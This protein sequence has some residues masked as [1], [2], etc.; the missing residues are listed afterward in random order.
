M[1]DSRFF[2]LYS[3]ACQF[4]Q[5]SKIF[6]YEIPD[7]FQHT[8]P[9]HTHAHTHT[10][11][12]TWAI[13][14]R[15]SKTHIKEC[16]HNE[17]QKRIPSKFYHFPS[18]LPY[19][20]HLFLEDRKIENNFPITHYLFV[21]IVSLNWSAPHWAICFCVHWR[22]KVLLF[23]SLTFTSEII[24]HIIR[25]KMFSCADITCRRRRPKGK[26]I[27]SCMHPSPPLII[28]I[29]PSQLI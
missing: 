29:I 2:I 10:H 5:I 26:V 6:V 21:H 7:E 25:V 17:A 13:R 3:M 18:F 24:S 9:N 15:Y 11:V 19:H 27:V 12:S 20:M 28:F 8:H 16:I 1:W 23:S 4:C 14:C 22:W